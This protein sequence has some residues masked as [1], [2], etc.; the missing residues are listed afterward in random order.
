MFEEKQVEI[1]FQLLER[2]RP[3]LLVIENA[4]ARDLLEKQFIE[5]Y[6]LTPKRAVDKSTG[7]Q[8]IKIEGR[9]VPI[10][11]TGMLSGQRA[12]D[13]GSRK[14]LEWHMT[15]ALNQIP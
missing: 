8:T 15:K 9:K 5:E 13:K 11:F 10:F 14:R 6:S 4:L 7:Y 1:F 3:R 12:L 2:L